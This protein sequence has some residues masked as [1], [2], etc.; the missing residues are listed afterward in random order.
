MYSFI[1]RMMTVDTNTLTLVLMI[2]ALGCLIMHATLPVPVLAIFAYPALVVSALAAR[3]LM[4]ETNLIMSMEKGPGIA[5]M[6]GFGMIFAL[7][8]IVV[9]VRVYMLIRDLSSRQPDLL[10]PTK[11]PTQ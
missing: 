8:V 1:I 7:T 5:L 2:C 3:I 4:A 11:Q 6:T 9:L 10:Q